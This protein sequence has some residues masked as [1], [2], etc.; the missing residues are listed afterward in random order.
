MEDLRREKEKLREEKNDILI[1]MNKQ[2]ETEKTEKRNLKT[3]C[4]KS[5]I[6]IRQFE[7]ENSTFHNKLADKD[8]QISRLKKVKI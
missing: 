6:K 3:E 1:R 2:L 5:Y 4:D 7:N 8:S